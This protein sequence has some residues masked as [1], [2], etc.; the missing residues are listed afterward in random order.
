MSGGKIR[1]DMSSREMSYTRA[2]CCGCGKG[3]LCL[4]TGCC[5]VAFLSLRF[6]LNRSIS[7]QVGSYF[8]LGLLRV[9]F[10]FA[11]LF[12]IFPYWPSLQSK[13]IGKVDDT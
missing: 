1:G 7:A 2:G 4:P 11:Y 6:V 10:V 5:I 9:I 3:S 13:G 8:C 12:I